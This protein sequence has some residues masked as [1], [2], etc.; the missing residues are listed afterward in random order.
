[1]TN[2]ERHTANVIIQHNVWT[3]Q[4]DRLKHMYLVMHELCTRL[5]PRLCVS[6]VSLKQIGFNNRF[7]IYPYRMVYCLTFYYYQFGIIAFVVL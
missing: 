4:M 1:M 3:N 7:I 6:P 5:L 2:T